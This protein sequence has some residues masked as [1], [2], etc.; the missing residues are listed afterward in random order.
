MT[1]TI[2][3]AKTSKSGFTPGRVPQ[4]AHDPVAQ[5]RGIR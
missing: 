3:G 4:V 5:R 2:I 1:S